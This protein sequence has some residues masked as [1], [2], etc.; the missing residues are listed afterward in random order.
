MILAK[1]GMFRVSAPFYGQAPADLSGSCA[2]I[3][4]YG[5]RDA[6]TRKSALKLA[7]DLPALGI[8]HE[9]KIYPNA[10]HSFMTRAPNRFMSMIGP[11]LPGRA[12]FE[13]AAAKDA[14]QRLLAFFKKHLTP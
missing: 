14:T 3:A 12:G 6:V 9:L 1:S 13:P 2:M 11:R 8:T 7:Q 4:S 10:G 5:G